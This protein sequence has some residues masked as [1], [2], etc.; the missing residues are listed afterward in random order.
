M[1]KFCED[2]GKV[3]EANGGVINVEE[4]YVVVVFVGMAIVSKVHWRVFKYIRG[5]KARRGAV[6]QRLNLV[7][8]E[9][10]IGGV[11]SPRE[12]ISVV[13]VKRHSDRSAKAAKKAG[14][15]VIVDEAD[16]T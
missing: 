8:F 1:R 15:A 5:R 13:R 12:G 10:F 6:L 11:S 9:V 7:S 3:I 4:I 2:I 14:I 16:L